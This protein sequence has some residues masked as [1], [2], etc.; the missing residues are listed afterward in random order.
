M[1][2]EIL[3]GLYQLV[4]RCILVRVHAQAVPDVGFYGR[5]YSQREHARVHALQ[6][7]EPLN[8][9]RC[10]KLILHV[11]IIQASGNFR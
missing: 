4:K 5:K 1:A 7:L 6:C 8:L 11:F 3:E 10:R 9:L 2:V